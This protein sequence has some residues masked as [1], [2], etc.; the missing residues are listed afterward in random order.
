MAFKEVGPFGTVIDEETGQLAT[1]ND[2]LQ[3]RVKTERDAFGGSFQLPGGQASK[4]DLNRRRF[5]AGQR[6][7]PRLDSAQR[8]FRGG[9]E[10]LIAT[11]QA[12]A[13]GTAGP[14][15]AEQQQ[16]GA[17]DDILKQQ[18]G[19]AASS[20]APAGL[21][22]RQTQRTGAEL[23]GTAAQDMGVLR[24][25]EQQAAQQQLAAVLGQ[26]RTGDIDVGGRDMA[27]Q[28]QQTALNDALVRRFTELGVSI[29][30]AQLLA[31]IEMEKLLEQQRQ[32]KTASK[33][34]QEQMGLSMVQAFMG[35]MAGGAGAGTFAGAG[36]GGGT[37]DRDTVPL[38]EDASI[39][40]ALD[41][42]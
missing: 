23:Q 40:R 38:G 32:R 39:N 37:S 8:Q 21:A 42:L 7:A 1:E 17:V 22:L 36:P 12:Q 28:L 19:A 10:D 33:R 14:S 9:Q 31:N 6:R 4:S 26:A 15:I 24:A 13:A 30:Q 2:L 5:E 11:L 20:G 41:T 16:R 27:A 18:L 34:A 35:G 3:E 29:D 25:Q